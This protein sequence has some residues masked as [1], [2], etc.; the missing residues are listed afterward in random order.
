[1]MSSSSRVRLAGLFLSILTFVATALTA[2]RFPAEVARDLGIPITSTTLQGSTT[3]R[4]PDGTPVFGTVIRGEP[5]RLYIVNAI[6]GELLRNFPLD[7]AKGSWNATTASDGSVYVGTDANGAL[8]RYIPGEEDIHHLG[9]VMPGQTWVWDVVAGRDGEV[10][11]ATFPSCL[12]FRYHPDDGFSDVGGGPIVPEEK[13]ARAL[14]YHEESDRLFVGIATHAHLFE[15]DPRTGEKRELLADRLQGKA[16]VYA[17]HLFGDRL[18]VQVQ[19]GNEVIVLDVNTREVEAVL[20]DVGTQFVASE[21]SPYDGKIYYFAG[22]RIRSYDSAD[23][24][25][26]II[27]NSP[28]ATVWKL[29][30]ME[31]DDP[32]YPGHTLVG[33]TQR[34]W[35]VRY[36][37]LSGRFERVGGELPGEPVPIHSIHTGPDGRIYT[38]GYLSG[39]F[40]I[41]DPEK[42]LSEH[43]RSISQIEYMANFGTDIYLGLYPRGRLYVFDSTRPWEGDSNPRQVGTLHDYNQTRP[44]AL[45]AAEDLNKVFIGTIPDYGHIGGVFATFDR[46]TG[47]LDV[48]P[49]FIDE[50]AIV[51][52]AR[53]KEGLI[54]GSTTISAG[55]GV[56]PTKTDSVL[57]L[58]DPIEGKK[59]FE[60]APVSDAWIVS[61]LVV[62]PDGLV[63][64]MAD[65][66]LFIFDS[67]QRKVVH[68]EHVLPIDHSKRMGLSR[69]AYMVYHPNGS[70][71][72]TAGSRLFRIDPAT[73]EFTVLIERHA[74]LLALDHEGNIYF[75]DRT[76]LW[77]FTPPSSER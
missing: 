64:G 29:H 5:A 56:N 19:E 44:V 13:Y 14:A 32:D 46:E 22:T 59:V 71:Y 60:V 25:V 16:W 18:L 74:N 77:Q 49:N 55:G 54:V 6:T 73:R 40:G 35:L 23:G 8:Y 57:F 36:H 50:Q 27:P 24:E 20:D 65:G 76:N 48:V 31:L 52:L 7:G 33:L 63:W 30:W 1:M 47:S 26:E 68:T 45:L 12:V 38:G 53:T 39:G 21:P 3:T 72:G 10:F 17:M 37:P 58:Y 66:H 11:G 67:E 69:D 43:S 62:T 15:L 41:Y 61:G 51:S 2:A 28:G 70:I 4:E 9:Q 34:G 42:D 75:R